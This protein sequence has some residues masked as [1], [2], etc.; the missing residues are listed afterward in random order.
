MKVR[1]IVLEPSVSRLGHACPKRDLVSVAQDLEVAF[2][3]L[4]AVDLPRGDKPKAPSRQGRGGGL[5]KVPLLDRSVT[6]TAD[7]I[8]SSPS[9]SM[10]Q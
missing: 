2:S 5:T 3:N 9:H 6:F 7:L 8:V 1:T 10:A 4:V